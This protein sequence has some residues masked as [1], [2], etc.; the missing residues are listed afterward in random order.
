MEEEPE[1]SRGGGERL[2]ELLGDGGA[3]NG[4]D[5]GACFVVEVEPELRVAGV[6]G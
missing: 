4:L 2:L 6:A 5:V 3:D 1:G